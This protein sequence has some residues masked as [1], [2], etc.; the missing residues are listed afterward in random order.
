MWEF[1]L[2]IWRPTLLNIYFQIYVAQLHIY[3]IIRVG[4]LRVFEHRNNILMCVTLTKPGNNLLN[5][6]QRNVAERAY[7]LSCEY[8][9]QLMHPSL[10]HGTRIEELS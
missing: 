2:H 8:L 7:A 4:K 5:M 3:V 9:S 10:M 1:Q 6:F